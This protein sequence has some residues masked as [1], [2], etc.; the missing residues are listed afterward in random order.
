MGFK[1][2]RCQ[3]D[4]SQGLR[5]PIPAPGAKL[6]RKLSYGQTLGP[7]LA[8][9][10]SFGSDGELCKAQSPWAVSFPLVREEGGFTGGVS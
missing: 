8:Q 7:G 10:G 1:T 2:D 4:V 9:M 5:F 3:E 6:G